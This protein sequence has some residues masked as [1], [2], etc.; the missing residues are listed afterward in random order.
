MGALVCSLGSLKME[1]MD[2]LLDSSLLACQQLLE[3]IS[4]DVC[5]ANF[6][7]SQ[8]SRACGFCLPFH[9]LNSVRLTGCLFHYPS[10]LVCGLTFLNKKR[11]AVV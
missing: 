2:I 10:D 6:L 3:G 1:H 8:C 5:G 4:P 9:A 7:P 11:L